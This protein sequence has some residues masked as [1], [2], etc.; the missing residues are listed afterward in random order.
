MGFETGYFGGR[1]AEP[2]RIFLNGMLVRALAGDGVDEA[3][4]PAYAPFYQ[5][6]RLSCRALPAASN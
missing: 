6:T 3:F 5:L 4:L 1:A 2:E